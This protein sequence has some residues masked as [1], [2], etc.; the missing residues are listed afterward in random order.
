MDILPA[1]RQILMA[2]HPIQWLK[3]ASIAQD[4]QAYASQQAQET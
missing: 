2:R 4:R 1:R 3:A